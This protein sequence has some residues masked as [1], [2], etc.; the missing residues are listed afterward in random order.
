VDCLAWLWREI[1]IE[2]EE[3]WCLELSVVCT[4]DIRLESVSESYLSNK[5]VSTVMSRLYFQIFV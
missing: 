4:Q 5:L 1:G 2:L 3:C